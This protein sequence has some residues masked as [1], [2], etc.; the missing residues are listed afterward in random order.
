VTI[1]W[2][3][4]NA[5]PGTSI[6]WAGQYEQPGY[7]DEQLDDAASTELQAFLN[8][9]P[10]QTQILAQKI[11][12]GCQIVSTSA[13]PAVT[14]TWALDPVT[15]FQIATAATSAAQF[16]LPRGLSTFTYPDITGALHALSVSD[17]G[18]LFTTLRDYLDEVE[19][20]GA[21]LIQGGQ[22]SYPAQPV[23]IA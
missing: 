15:Q 6:S 3:H 2:V 21:T 22:A 11:A 4:R 14:G 12:A 10:T 1:W 7:A 23:P 19:Q 20:A 16:G 5:G 13:H 18:I 17:L 8:P 9:A